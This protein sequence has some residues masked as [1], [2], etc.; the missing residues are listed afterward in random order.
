MRALPDASTSAVCSAACASATALQRGRLRRHAL[1]QVRRPRSCTGAGRRA[2]VAVEREP[3]GLD[4]ERGAQLVEPLHARG[5]ERGDARAAVRLDDDEALGLERAQRRADGVA[6]D[7][8]G[9]AELLL[10]SRVAAGS[11]PSRIRVAQRGGERVD[12]R[13]A[14]ERRDR[15]VHARAS[16]TG[17]G[18]TRPLRSRR[19]GSASAASPAR[20]SAPPATASGPGRSASTTAPSTLAVSGS[21]SVSVAVSPAARWRRPRAKRT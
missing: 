16:A 12:R 21:A 18:A 10:A 17:D 3:R 14:L 11:P 9:P 7:V 13:A 2:A 6:R 1:R 15:G 4:L 5:V 20:T 8:V 19:A